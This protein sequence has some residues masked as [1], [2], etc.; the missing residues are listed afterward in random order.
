MPK[1]AEP[2]PEA[3]FRKGAETL[4]A[5]N[6]GREKRSMATRVRLLFGLGSLEAWPGHGAGT[7]QVFHGDVSVAISGTEISS[8]LR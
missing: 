5:K 8:V 6:V 7:L 2:S 1:S 3:G 4:T